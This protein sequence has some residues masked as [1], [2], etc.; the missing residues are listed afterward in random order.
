MLGDGVLV[1]DPC[2]E[3]GAGVGRVL[4][5]SGCPRGSHGGRKSPVP[6][7]GGGFAVCPHPLH[8]GAACGMGGHPLQCGVC[9]VMWQLRLSQHLGLIPDWSLGSWWGS[10]PHMGGSRLS[11][12]LTP[13]IMSCR[14]GSPFV[15]W[16]LWGHSGVRGDVWAGEW[17][18]APNPS[19][20]R[21][22]SRARSCAR[23]RKPRH[24][25]NQ[26]NVRNFLPGRGIHEIN[27]KGQ[28]KKR[29]SRPRIKPWAGQGGR[30][31]AGSAV[32]PA[33]EAVG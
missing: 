10:L 22:R 29:S 4:G 26:L 1:W 19:R 24:R 30:K 15:G 18:A 32:V 13:C 2:G 31:A 11:F 14:A 6:A 25:R 27:G 28:K 33:P 17:G 9:G 5:G 12:P 16:P 3:S 21:C 8:Q 7:A 20:L 23:H